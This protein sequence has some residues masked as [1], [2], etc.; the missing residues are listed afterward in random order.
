MYAKRH[1]RFKEFLDNG[2]FG[3]VL[4]SSS[5]AKTE[6][7]ELCANSGCGFNENNKCT[8]SGTQCFGYMEV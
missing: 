6:N 7:I 8:S 1:I 2:G 3:E 4:G 5:G